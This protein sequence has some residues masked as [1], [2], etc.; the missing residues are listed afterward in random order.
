MALRN[1][2]IM[3]CSWLGLYCCPPT[4]LLS[5]YSLSPHA[6]PL[7]GPQAAFLELFAKHKDS[8]GK[9]AKLKS[10]AQLQ[11]LLDI[12][13]DLLAAM[14]ARDK[15]AAAARR[16]SGLAGCREEEVSEVVRLYGGGFVVARC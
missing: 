6:I 2:Q 14:D 7:V 4:V 16:E 15:E 9:Q 1:L 8:K 3:T 13:R 10:P 5:T 11:E 12:T